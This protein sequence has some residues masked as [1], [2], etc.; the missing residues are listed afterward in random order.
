VDFENSVIHVRRSFTLD[1]N[2]RRIEGSTKTRQKR[3]VPM[4]APVAELL[5]V[6][7]ASRKK[8]SWVFEGSKGDALNDGWFRKNRFAPA[9]QKLGLEGITIHNL[10]HTCASL[11][12]RLG[13]PVTNVSRILGHSTVVQT[14]NTY[15]HFYQD[16]IKDSMATLGNAFK[17]VEISLGQ[18]AA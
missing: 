10:R 9:V 6:E 3:T 4:P 7:L 11:L 14:L 1:A 17:A 8:S 12:I 5:E 2:Y 13:N 15:G 16:D 18:E